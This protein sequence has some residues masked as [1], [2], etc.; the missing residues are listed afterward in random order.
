MATGKLYRFQLSR[1]VPYKPVTIDMLNVLSNIE[2]V[3][4][5]FSKKLLASHVIFGPLIEFSEILTAK[6]DIQLLLQ[7]DARIAC[8]FCRSQQQSTAATNRKR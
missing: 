3:M 2:K 5:I 7:R 6:L 1:N 4:K 8:F